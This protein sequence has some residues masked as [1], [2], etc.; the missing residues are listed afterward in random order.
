[1]PVRL[2][3]GWAGRWRKSAAEQGLRARGVLYP[4]CLLLQWE[5]QVLFGPSSCCCRPQC[6][7]ADRRQ[8]GWLGPPLVLATPE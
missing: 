5:G 8:G 7:A 2:L 6:V 1:M 4:A 3:A